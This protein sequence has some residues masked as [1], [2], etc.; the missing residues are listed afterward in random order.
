MRKEDIKKTLRQGY[1]RVAKGGGS[2]CGPQTTGC[3]GIDVTGVISSNDPTAKAMLNDENVNK[4]DLR[5]VGKAVRSAR[6][7][8]RKPA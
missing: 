6:V 7:S 1:A 5:K 8:A 3:C 4:D 2:C